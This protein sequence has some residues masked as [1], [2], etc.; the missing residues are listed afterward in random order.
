MKFVG[1]GAR[2]SDRIC[3]RGAY[4]ACSKFSWGLGLLDAQTVSSKWRRGAGQ[5]QIEFTPAGQQLTTLPAAQ[6]EI[7]YDNGPILKPA[8]RGRTDVFSP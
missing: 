6:R 4:L 1:A 7:R 8:R 2:L 3:G 5:V